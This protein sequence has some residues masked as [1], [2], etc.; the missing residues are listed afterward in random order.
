MGMVFEQFGL[1]R[2]AGRCFGWLLICSPPHQ[3][4]AQLGEAVGASKGSVSSM[5]RLLMR[6]S[7]IERFSVPGERAVRYRITEGSWSQMMDAKL[8]GIR[9]MR[10]L[11][12][13]GAALLRGEEARVRERIEQM[14]DIYVFFEREWPLLI[15]RYERRAAAR[16]LRP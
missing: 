2:M 11:A 5:V 7:L 8:Q 14:R 4:A 15:E 13:R 9:L 1:P 12:E 16:G 10:A 6:S 3:T